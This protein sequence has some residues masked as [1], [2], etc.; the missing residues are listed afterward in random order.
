MTPTPFA[1]FDLVLT[2]FIGGLGATVLSAFLAGRRERIQRRH[3]FVERQLRDFYSPLLGLRAEIRTRSELRVK[4]HGVADTVW[5]RLVA[6]ARARGGPEATQQMSE[7]RNAEFTKIIDYDNE[8]LMQDLLPAY[9]SMVKVF[10][11]N[12]WL[13]DEDT[14]TFFGALIEFIEIWDRWTANALPAEVADELDHSEETLHPFYDHLEQRHND[15][16]G[17]LAQGKA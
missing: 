14:R 8:R 17:K 11:E 15:L 12:M 7:A 10:R 3:A 6:E 16:R 13:A 4:I 1:W 9:R 5:R 2:G